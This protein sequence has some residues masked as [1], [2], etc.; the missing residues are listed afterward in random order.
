MKAKITNPILDLLFAGQAVRL[1]PREPEPWL[2]AADVCKA[3]GLDSSDKQLSRLPAE[4][5]HEVV[6]TGELTD[7]LSVNSRERNTEL[8]DNFTV[9]SRRRG[10]PKIAIISP[11]AVMYLAFRSRKPQ[12]MSFVRWLLE[13]VLPQIAKYGVYVAGTDPAERCTLLWH[14]WKLER[15]KEI[16]HANA[17][18][19]RRG[20]LTI[21]LFAE[22]NQVELRDVLSFARLASQEAIAAGESRARVYTRGGMRRAYSDAVLRAALARLQPRLPWNEDKAD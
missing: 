6:N 12:A 4:L 13:E 7:K 22:L 21:A 9:N 15:E 11:T 2:V 18:L 5:R 8:T 14:R 10:T 17:E 3:L 16:G 20:L 1:V 19:E